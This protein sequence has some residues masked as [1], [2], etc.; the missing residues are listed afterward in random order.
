[1]Q[2]VLP[3]RI[4]ARVEEVAGHA[5]R[6]PRIVQVEADDALASARGNRIEEG[7]DFLEVVGAAPRDDGVHRER[8]P[9]EGVGQDVRNRAGCAP[10][11][12]CPLN[13]SLHRV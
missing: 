12:G 1:M 8:G 6:P 9:L 13:E 7:I 3:A 11:L 2:V 5:R 10:V 4:R